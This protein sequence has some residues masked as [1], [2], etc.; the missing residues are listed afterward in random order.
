MKFTR[1]GFLKLS[2]LSVAVVA[3][4]LGFDLEATAAHGHA[5]KLAGCTKIPSIC[6]FCSGGCGLLLHIKDG[7]LVHLD[8]NPDNPINEGTLCPKAASLA[9]V[10]YSPERPKNPLYRAPGSDKF[11]DI[12]WEEAYD[13]IAKKIKEVRDKTW[14][15]TEEITN[16]K[17]GAKETVTV[18]RAEGICMIGS[19]E[20][21]NEESYLLSKLARLIGTPFHEHQARI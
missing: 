2:G 10:A 7:K 11:V 14:T 19:A 15:S 16:A 13:R 21:D 6:H 8:G 5:L 17:T 20:V 3:S 18:N 4:G 12:S 9:Q 1:R